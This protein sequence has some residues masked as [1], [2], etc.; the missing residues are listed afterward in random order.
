MIEMNPSAA[1]DLSLAGTPIGYVEQAGV[2]QPV[3]ISPCQRKR[4]VHIIGMA[5]T[6]KSTLMTHMVL[7]DIRR[8]DGVAVLDSRGDVVQQ[9]LCH[10]PARDARR[11]VYFNPGDPDYVPLWNPLRCGASMSRSRIT[12]DLVCAFRSVFSRWSDRLEH[13]LRHAFFAILHLPNGT[14]LDI[15]NLLRK[16]S[17]ESRR[18]RDQLLNV[19]DNELALQF[20]RNDFDGYGQ[21]ELL[22]PLHKLSKLLASETVGAMLSQGRSAFDLRDVMDSGKILLVDLSTVG[23]EVRN[24]LGCFILSLLH[25]AA[26]AR[27]SSPGAVHQ[28]F[29]IYCDEAHRFLTDAMEDLISGTR[30]FRV[31]L[32]LAHQYMSQFSARTTDALSG[33]GSTIMF[34]VNR[35]DAEH[36]QK[37]LQGEVSLKDLSTLEFGQGI[38]RI[39]NCI[40]RVRTYPP[41]A[42]GQATHGDDIV[43]YSRVRYYRP[44]REMS[45]PA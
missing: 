39:G 42:A 15:A 1:A 26:L 20:W 23:S 4:H 27:N 37:E 13:L 10:I 9:L 19:I 16:K 3:L 25:L 44:V 21:Q 28:P 5:G 18:L 33:V 45:A 34:R 31:S 40:S 24:M 8:G 35:N 11:V 6:G 22:P 38:A 12:D 36:L 2:R 43:R 7:D 32:T 14:L 41:L 30:M 29:H 17:P